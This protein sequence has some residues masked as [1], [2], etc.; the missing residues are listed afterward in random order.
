MPRRRATRRQRPVPYADGHAPD[1]WWVDLTNGGRTCFDTAF[2]D[3]VAAWTWRKVSGYAACVQRTADGPQR[4]VYLHRLIA[5]AEHGD[6]SD[7]DHLNH[8]KLDN[9]AVNLRRVTHAEN[10]LARRAPRRHH[11]LPVGVVVQ[12]GRFIARLD[13]LH[14]GS[15]DTPAEASVRY[16][17]CVR[18]VRGD[19]VTPE[20]PVGSPG[21]VPEDLRAR[22]AGAPRT[23]VRRYR[24]VHPPSSAGGGYW[25][26]VRHNRQDVFLGTWPSEAEAARA[27]DSA[28]LLLGRASRNF[29]GEPAISLPTEVR[30]RLERVAGPA[31]R[32]R[33]PRRPH[34]YAHPDVPGVMCVPLT[35]SERVALIDT[36]DLPAVDVASWTLDGNGYA[37]AKVAGRVW[38]MHTYLL[39]VPRGVE[40]DH[41]NQDPLDNRRSNLR[42]VTRTQNA[43]NRR[44]AKNSSSRFK[45]VSWIANGWQ[46]SIQVGGEAVYLGRFN[47]EVQAARTYDAAAQLAWREHARL[48]LP[49]EEPVVLAAGVVEK[50]RSAARRSRS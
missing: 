23:Y 42:A 4:T 12:D 48:N 10:L 28:S 18:L 44:S 6:K 33:D 9:R 43:A 40:V 32:A 41:I 39:E 17:A 25:A 16:E 11:D 45:G 29:P 37:F 7:V 15:F 2:K 30:R 20:A 1:L 34:P 5:G 46:V 36:A 35:G 38:L 22:L 19:G 31:V 27:Y 50:L 24:G 26:T 13:G 21:E 47:D 3:A 49:G 14:L 8:D